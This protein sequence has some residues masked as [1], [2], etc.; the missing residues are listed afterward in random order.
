LVGSGS[1]T[2]N[3]LNKTRYTAGFGVTW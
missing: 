1:G 2:D 3:T